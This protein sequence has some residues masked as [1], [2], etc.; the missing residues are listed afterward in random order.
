MT[1]DAN[2]CYDKSH[3]T[4]HKSHVRF[5]QRLLTSAPVLNFF[6]PFI[7]E[8]NKIVKCVSNNY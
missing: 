2:F 7:K 8:V 5:L 3:V 6:K 4:F 1:Q